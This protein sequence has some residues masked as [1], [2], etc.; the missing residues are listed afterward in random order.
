MTLTNFYYLSGLILVG[1]SSPA[2][3]A[4]ERILLIPGIISWVM[5]STFYDHIISEVSL[6]AGI[7]RAAIEVVVTYLVVLNFCKAKNKKERALASFIGL[8]GANALGWTIG[9]VAY[10]ASGLVVLSLSVTSIILISALLNT[11]RRSLDL[12]PSDAMGP[13]VIT[14]LA[15]NLAGMVLYPFV[16]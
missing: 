13:T 12:S 11:Y 1:R 5:A 9:L 2:Y 15:I 4:G 10:L 16:A 14:V 8:T 7:I 6:T 3:F